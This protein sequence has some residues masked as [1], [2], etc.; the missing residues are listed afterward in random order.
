MFTNRNVNKYTKRRYFV[1]ERELV[2]LLLKF[3][4]I[5]M[6]YVRVDYAKMV[7]GISCQGS[8]LLKGELLEHEEEL[9][10]EAKVEAAKKEGTTSKDIKILNFKEI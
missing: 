10:K 1:T 3:G 4:G 5:D 7:N 2:T 6:A 9:V 8:V